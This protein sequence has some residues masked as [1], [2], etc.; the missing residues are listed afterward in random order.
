MTVR[1][2]I[3]RAEATLPGVERSARERDPRWQ[4]ILGV[5]EYSKSDPEAVWTFIECW[6]QHEDADLRMAVGLCLLEHLLGYHFELIFPRVEQLAVKSPRFASSFRCCR[7]MGQA[8]APRQA[9]R[10]D[11][12]LEHLNPGPAA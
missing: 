4:V 10:W 8:E 2:A 9:K 5:S 11:T 7:K 12:L 3:K 6:G 1:Q